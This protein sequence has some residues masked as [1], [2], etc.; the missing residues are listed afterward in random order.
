ME[1]VH[2]QDVG[3]MLSVA[4]PRVGWAADARSSWWSVT[5]DRGDSLATKLPD[6]ALATLCSYQ[7]TRN[8]WARLTPLAV[9]PTPACGLTPTR[10]LEQLAAAGRLLR[11]TLLPVVDELSAAAL[12]Q[13]APR[14]RSSVRP[15]GTTSTRSVA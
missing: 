1:A 10:Y 7:V 8:W 11:H 6:L 12:G 9:I 3:V 5:K 4:D 15:G 13:H 2:H 14:W